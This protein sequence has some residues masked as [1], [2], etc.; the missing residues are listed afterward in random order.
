MNCLFLTNI[1]KHSTFCTTFRY[2]LML[3][4]AND[5]KAWQAIQSPRTGDS[6][7]LMIHRW[8]DIRF[9]MDMSKALWNLTLTKATVTLALTTPH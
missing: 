1:V 6:S 3:N 4:N 7:L 2:G 8:M 9:L 5:K